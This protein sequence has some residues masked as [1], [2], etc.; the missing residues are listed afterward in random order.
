MVLSP[1]DSTSD[2]RSLLASVRRVVIKVGTN[3]IMRDDGG[4]AI[5]R[6]YG[7]VEAV[8]NLRK[9]GKEVMLVSSGAVGLGAQRLGLK[10]KPHLLPVKQACAAIG[11]SSL[12][13]IYEQGFDK[14][15][16]ITAQVLLTEDDFSTRRRYLNLRT[17]LEKIIELGAVPIINEND[18]VSTL[19]LGGN[20]DP[21]AH[22]PVFGD[23]DKLS[24]L[25][26]S[27]VS[28]DLL[29]LL[30]DVDGLYTANPRKDNTAEL[31]PV[32]REITPEIEAIAEGAGARGRGGMKTKIEAARIA[33][34]SGGM[35]IIANGRSPGVIDR[36]FAGEQI[37]TV[38]VPKVQLPSK[39]R[40][41]AFASPLSGRIIINEG[42]RRAL[43]EGKASLLPAG[44][45]RVE[46]NFEKGDVVGIVDP[47][48]KEFARG[49]VNY[50]SEEASKMLGLQ[51]ADIDEQLL[52][53]KHYDA[54]ITR[55][56]IVLLP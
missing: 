31:L 38:F 16:V 48:D 41:I 37:G 52:P 11:Q 51:S 50:S 53:T 25:V 39:K 10:K 49:M 26:M 24:A 3:V 42:A 29:V 13:A 28:A 5:G 35:A 30:S 54:L 12:M 44:V 32:V 1:S 2:L 21:A 7:L 43:L 33:T 19:E 36:L 22:K 23:N 40:W 56:N 8:A 14:L 18:T 4:V 47:D 45:L 27:K 55:D 6:I 9:E 46:D 15:G 34:Q 17:A 20:E